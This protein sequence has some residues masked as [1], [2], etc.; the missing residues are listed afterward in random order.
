MVCRWWAGH[1]SLAAVALL[2]SCSQHFLSRPRYLDCGRNG[3]YLRASYLTFVLEA[4]VCQDRIERLDGA[5]Q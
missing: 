3:F 2:E 4:D 5:V 1:V